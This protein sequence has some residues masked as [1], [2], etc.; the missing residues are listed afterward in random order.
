MAKKKGFLQRLRRSS[1]KEDK[2]IVPHH[3]RKSYR[4]KKKE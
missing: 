3:T 1:S 4:E 2:K